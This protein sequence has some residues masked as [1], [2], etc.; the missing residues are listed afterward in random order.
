VKRTISILAPL[1]VTIAPVQSTGKVGAV[2]IDAA[3]QEA[4]E[5]NLGLAAERMNI[6][7]TGARIITARLRPT[8]VLM[9]SGQSLNLLRAAYSPNTPRGQNQL[10]VHTGIP[11]ERGCKR[12]ERIAV[13]GAGRPLANPVCGK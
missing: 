3:I 6:S 13:A 2:T 10:S 9:V 11:F 12:E 4:V 5:H 7:V 1:A 8:P